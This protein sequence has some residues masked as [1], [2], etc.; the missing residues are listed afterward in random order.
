MPKFLQS[1]GVQP[2]DSDERL[3]TVK[4]KPDATLISLTMMF[5]RRIAFLKD[6]RPSTSSPTRR[7][8]SPVP[9]A[10]FAPVPVSR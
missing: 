9:P 5:L 7:P 10:F 6:F 4:D 1:A 3:T 8:A 2:S